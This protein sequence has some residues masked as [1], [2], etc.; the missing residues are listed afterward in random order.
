VAKASENPGQIATLIL[1]GDTSWQQ[2]GAPV[3]C[4]RARCRRRKVPEAARVEHVAAVL[5]SGE[6]TLIILAGRATRGDALAQAGKSRPPPAA[7]SRPSSSAR[8]SSAAPGACR[9]SASPTRC[10]WRSNS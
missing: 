3:A 7:A 1:P 10:R 6:P 4:C 5:R 2:A 8:A 9:W